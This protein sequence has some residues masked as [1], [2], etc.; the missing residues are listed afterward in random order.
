MGRWSIFARYLGRQGVGGQDKLDGRRGC[1][2]YYE[3]GTGAAGTEKGD[4]LR[5]ALTTI[6]LASPPAKHLDNSNW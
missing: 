2:S 6:P 5:C 1:I 4:G 3:G